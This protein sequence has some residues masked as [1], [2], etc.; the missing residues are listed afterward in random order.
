M[1]ASQAPSYMKEGNILRLLVQRVSSASVSIEEQCVGKIG[2]GYLVFIG[3]SESDT[4]E[5]AKKMFDKI[6]KLRIFADE[7]GKTN[8]NIEQTNGEWLLVSQ[9]TLYA[10]C[11]KGNRPSFTEAGNPQ[12]AKELYEYFIRLVKEKYGKCEKGEFGADMQVS[13]CN[14]GPFTIFLDSDDIIK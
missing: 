4:E 10:N 6:S 7:E 5:I 8:C 9:F 11:R 2:K 1:P 3:V 14:D 12:K 13:L